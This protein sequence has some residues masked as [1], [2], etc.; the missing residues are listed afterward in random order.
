MVRD[1]V[2]ERSE[3][4]GW[5]RRMSK[6]WAWIGLGRERAELDVVGEQI[7]E[8]GPRS[9]RFICHVPHR[10]RRCLTGPCSPERRA[11]PL[12]MDVRLS[13]APYRLPLWAMRAARRVRCSYW[14]TRACW[15][16]WPVV[17]LGRPACTRSCQ[18][19]P[20]SSPRCSVF[21]RESNRGF[22]V[23]H[24]LYP[25]AGTSGGQVSTVGEVRCSHPL[26][27]GLRRTDAHL[28]PVHCQDPCHLDLEATAPRV[29]GVRLGRRH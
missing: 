22:G 15:L 27:V 4:M 21:S 28:R 7:G 11:R 18:W 19:S 29:V 14:P 26:H 8:R 20:T 16:D 23:S 2:Q 9:C 10:V 24:C 6:P 5:R 12:L 25:L 13:T 1:F 17:L 3:L